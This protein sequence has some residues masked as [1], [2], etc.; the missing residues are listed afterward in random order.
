M[1][2]TIPILLLMM[3][4]LV[5]AQD[6]SDQEQRIAEKIEQITPELIEVRRH[7]HENP[8]RGSHDLADPD[9]LGAAGHG[10]QRQ[11]EQTGT[12]N[13]YGKDRGVIDD[14]SPTLFQRILPCL[15]IIQERIGEGDA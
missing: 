13:Q 12:G 14:P 5:F 7:L 2:R 6:M 15:I 3:T 11:A 9:L 1:K 8:E 10:Q 4:S